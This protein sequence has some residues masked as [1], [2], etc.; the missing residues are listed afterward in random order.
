MFAHI[1]FVFSG[2]GRSL[3][4]PSREAVGADAPCSPEA[5]QGG[6]GSAQA[7]RML[8]LSTFDS[9]SA[10]ADGAFSS[11]ASPEPQN[12]PDCSIG[13]Y[14]LNNIDVCNRN[15]QL[16][17]IRLIDSAK[18][19]RDALKRCNNASQ[20]QQILTRAKLCFSQAWAIS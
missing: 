4:L 8:C 19:S 3:P 2:C 5:M 16:D 6:R 10:G 15:R 1:R 13:R 18:I 17:L 12:C 20:N 9:C 14:F 11:Q 7:G